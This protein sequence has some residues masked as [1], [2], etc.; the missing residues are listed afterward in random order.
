MTPHLLILPRRSHGQGGFMMVEVL[1][2]ILL[3]AIGVLG[4]VGLQAS[5][6]QAQTAGKFRADAAYL[7]DELKGIMWTDIA[8]LANYTSANCSG[9]AL[10]AGW[11]NKVA[12]ALPGGAVSTLTVDTTPANAS[13]GD[14]T[15]TLSWTQPN[16]GTHSYTTLANVR[17]SE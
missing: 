4:I 11:A 1:V 5:M 3:F 15:I 7:A 16:G 12:S 6:A 17:A 10:C 9:Y 13:F 14:A 8:N 2:A